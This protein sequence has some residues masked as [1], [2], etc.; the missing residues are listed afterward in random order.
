MRRPQKLTKSSPSIWQYVLTVK[1]TMKISSI[2]VAFLENMNFNHISNKG[3]DYAHQ[4]ILE[5]R[6]FRPSDGPVHSIT[7]VSKSLWT[8]RRKK[9][10][11]AKSFEIAKLPLF[12]QVQFKLLF[13]QRKRG[14]WVWKRIKGNV[15]DTVELFSITYFDRYVYEFIRYLFIKKSS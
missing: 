11:F 7:K 2:F 8:G 10:H 12:L 3:T 4:I 6:I 9:K 15:F 14:L 1:S 13:F 5:P